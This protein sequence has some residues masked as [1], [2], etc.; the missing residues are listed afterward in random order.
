MKRPAFLTLVLLVFSFTSGR[1][2]QPQ[3]YSAAE[4]HLM[5][6]KMLVLGSVLHVGA[7]PD[8]ENNTLIAYLAKGRLVRTAFLSATRGD[9]GQNHIG[10]EKG[11]LMGILRTQEL[12]AARRID[13][14]EQF[15]TRAIDFGYSLS[16]DET[17]RTWDRDKVRADFV[18]I[19]RTFKP[20]VI[21]AR[22]PTT[23]EGGHGHHTASAIL[24][25]EAFNAAADA[26]EYPEQLQHTKTWQ[27]KRLF[28]NAWPQI[29]ERRSGNVEDLIELDIGAFNPVLGKSYNEI[30]GEARSMHKCQGMGT[31]RRRGE[32][33]N[34]FQL[35]AGAPAKDDLFDDLDFSWKRVAGGETV[36]KLLKNALQD[37]EYQNPESVLPTLLEAEAALEK[38]SSDDHWVVQKRTELKTLIRACAGLWLEATTGSEAE[39]PGESVK[40]KLSALNRTGKSPVLKKVAIPEFKFEKTFGK[41]LSPNAMLSEEVLLKIPSDHAYSQPYWMVARKGKSMFAVENQKL[42]GAAENAPIMTA[43]YTVAFGGREVTFEEPVRYRWR[44]RIDGDRYQPFVVAPEVTVNFEDKVY[45]FADDSPQH[46]R[47]RL[48]NGKANAQ[49]MLRIELPSGWRAEPPNAPFSFEQKGGEQTFVVKVSPPPGQS[50]GVATAIVEIDGKKISH[51][52]FRLDYK[53]IPSQSFFPPAETKLVRL[54]L[55]KGDEKIGYVMGA[56]DE[57]PQNLRQLGYEVNLLEDDELEKGDL[58]VYDVIITGIRAYNTRERLKFTH[59]NLLDFIEKGG[60]LIIQYNHYRGLLVDNLGP[61]KMNLSFDRV[62]EEDADVAFV[63]AENR[64]LNFPNKITQADFENWVQERG[65]YFSNDYDE[66]YETVL[67]SQD[68][69]KSPHAGGM[70]YT[71]Y[72]NGH[73]IYTG[74]SWFRQMPA[75]VPG[76]FRLFVNLISAGMEQ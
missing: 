4:I 61:Y 45:I 48:K 28:W 16:P 5:L 32:S 17:L 43:V 30:A 1:A 40:L 14:G 50:E 66:R 7:H 44:D 20:D 73:F 3:F 71:K 55:K 56:G 65:M 8:D 6:Q 63:D 38:L 54:D 9:G 49:G 57:V 31:P 24:A 53:H 13:G 70:L 18:W 36:E 68:T 60:T 37:F 42:I 74:Y 41:A 23:G 51:S 22:F 62:T 52:L 10:D 75:G 11:D 27:P 47:L 64:F 69:G 2:Q 76:A 26:S 34:Y 33:I 25:D 12:L 72:G 58:S 19:V 46:L 29:V 67:S 59:Q 15:F 21:I 35:L 39:T